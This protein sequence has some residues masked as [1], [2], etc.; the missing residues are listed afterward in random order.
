MSLA[1]TPAMFLLLVEPV[2]TVYPVKTRP[3]WQHN[4]LVCSVNGFYPGHIEVRWFRNGQEEE[5][6]V[7]STGLIPNGDWTFQIMVML[8]VVPQG[9]EV[10]ACHVEHP[11]LTSPITVE[12]SE[13]LS[14]LI[15]FSAT[16]RGGPTYPRVSGL[17]FPHTSVRELHVL[18]S[19]S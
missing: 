19:F 17:T 8:E 7:V 9:G 18:F 1:L 10:Y 3:L 15:S 5:A 13:E 12:W 2:V 14:D 11:S 4:L 16:K 6:G